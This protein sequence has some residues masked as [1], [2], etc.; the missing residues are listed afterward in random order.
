MLG[1]SAIRSAGFTIAAAGLWASF[2]AICGRADGGEEIPLSRDTVIR[3]AGPQTGRRVLARRDKFIRSVS[4]FDVESRLGKLNATPDELLQFAADQVLPWEAALQKKIEPA[5]TVI[6]EK[7]ARYKVRLPKEILLI[8]TTGKEEGGAAY[9]R[10][11]N[12]IVLP[13]AVTDRRNQK[14]LT[15]LLMHELFHILSRNDREARRRL[16]GIVGF[17]ECAEVA[18]PAALRDRKITNPDAP[19]LEHYIEIQLDGSAAKAVPLLY[20]SVARFDP[21]QGGTFFK[22]LTF[23]LMLVHK[24]G[25]RW[26]AVMEGDAPRLIVPKDNQSFRK[27]IGGNTN[28]I[29]HPDEIL[30][31]NFVH[32]LTDAEQLQTPRIV[33]QMRRVLGGPP[34]GESHDDR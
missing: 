13:A 28:Y 17:R 14:Q 5:V 30:A 4:R 15:R 6:R 2:A 22:Y 11:M 16:Y 3:F 25:G 10:G 12:A 21:E 26:T 32:L 20:A 33:E 18:V 29:I 9:C 27:Q 23:R 31:D 34:P 1:K 24:A 7:L 19:T 8:R